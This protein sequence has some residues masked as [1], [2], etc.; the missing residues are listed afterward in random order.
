MDF[1]LV[2]I[3]CKLPTNFEKV[4]VKS[5]S[6][7]KDLRIIYGPITKQQ[8]SLSWPLGKWAIKMPFFYWCLLILCPQTVCRGNISFWTFQWPFEYEHLWISTVCSVQPELMHI[9][10]LWSLKR[11]V[12]LCEF[13][14]F[15]NY[16]LN[17]ISVR[18][19]ASSSGLRLKN[20]LSL[21]L[22]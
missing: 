13:V 1:I 20:S 11:T 8:F 7:Q 4:S 5:I 14:I 10:L 2:C 15:C 9:Y 22:F 18:V 16:P 3:C 12:F 6:D 21:W 17:W 19:N